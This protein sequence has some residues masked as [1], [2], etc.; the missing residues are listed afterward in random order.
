MYVRHVRDPSAPATEREDVDI[1]ALQGHIETCE[2]GE[3][4]HPQQGG[5]LAEFAGDNYPFFFTVFTSP[6]PH[7]TPSLFGSRRSGSSLP[8]TFRRP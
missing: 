5:A 6:F 8:L 1:E 2:P 3:G 7:A 4:A